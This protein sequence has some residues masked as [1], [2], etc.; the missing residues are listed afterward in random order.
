MAKPLIQ[1]HLSD[2]RETAK[3]TQRSL[4]HLES[5]I[6]LIEDSGLPVGYMNR[7]EMCDRTLAITDYSYADH[8]K[9]A[10]ENISNS[11]SHHEIYKFPEF[12][13]SVRPNRTE[14]ELIVPIAHR[15]FRNDIQKMAFKKDYGNDSSYMAHSER[16]GEDTNRTEYFF[17]KCIEFF[18][19]RNVPSH[20]LL[21]LDNSFTI[22]KK[23]CE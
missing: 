3:E 6:W 12:F 18:S 14:P 13:A 9:I 15:N 16:V 22:M 20:L 21:Q 5:Q 17:K 11:S 4:D 1:A 2:L 7:Y 10:T 8:F 23:M 19:N